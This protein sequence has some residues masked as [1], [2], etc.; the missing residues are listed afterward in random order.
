MLY[1]RRET[2]PFG[3]ISLWQIRMYKST[4]RCCRDRLPAFPSQI[5]LPDSDLTPID[6][7]VS[8][9]NNSVTIQEQLSDQL[10]KKAL[11]HVQNSLNCHFTNKK[12]ELICMLR[13]SCFPEHPSGRRKQKQSTYPKMNNYSVSALSTY[14][15]R[16][17][18]AMTIQTVANIYRIF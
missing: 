11:A 14:A 7:P 2:H 4:A 15:R 13:W 12:I 10:I 9:G 8:P 17:S 5:S 6:F 1:T 18:P 16:L 3:N